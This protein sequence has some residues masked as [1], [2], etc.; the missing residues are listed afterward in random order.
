MDSIRDI[1]VLIVKEPELVLPETG[2]DVSDRPRDDN[3]EQE[4]QQLRPLWSIYTHKNGVTTKILS[5][6]DEKIW[7]NESGK[8]I[9]TVL[10]W[11]SENNIKLYIADGIDTH[12]LMSVQINKT[13]DST[14]F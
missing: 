2:S 6:T 4:L 12:G 14:T 8:T 7:S 1:I 11:E 10:R 13:Y 9:A 5:C 3:E